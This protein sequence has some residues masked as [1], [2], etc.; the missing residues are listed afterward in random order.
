MQHKL[1]DAMQGFQAASPGQAPAWLHDGSSVPD[2]LHHMAHEASAATHRAQG[3]LQHSG[4]SACLSSAIACPSV[5]ALCRG[6]ELPARCKRLHA[7]YA[8]VTQRPSVQATLKGPDK[9]DF[10]SVLL[11]HYSKCAPRPALHCTALHC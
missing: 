8:L 7:W 9:Q 6:F 10:E 1:C 4:S 5:F 3:I 2:T 11:E